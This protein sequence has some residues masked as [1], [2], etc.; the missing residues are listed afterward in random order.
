[1][2]IKIIGVSVFSN[3]V[4]IEEITYVSLSVLGRYSNLTPLFNQLKFDKRKGSELKTFACF[5]YT[6]N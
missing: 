2:L 5:E 4:G 3:K 6:S 1:M